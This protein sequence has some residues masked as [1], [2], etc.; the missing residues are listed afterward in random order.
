MNVTISQARFDEL[1]RSELML[2]ALESAG[3]DNWNGYSYAWKKA[4]KAEALAEIE[5]NKVN[6]RV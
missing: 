4:K 5:K 2:S 6:K 1:L 3:V